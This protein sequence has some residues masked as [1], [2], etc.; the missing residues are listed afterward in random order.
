MALYLAFLDLMWQFKMESA[1]NLVYFQNKSS[2]SKQ[3]RILKLKVCVVSKSRYSNSLEDFFNIFHAR[4]LL[5]LCPNV[6]VAMEKMKN[7]KATVL[8]R[9]WWKDWNCHR[10]H[11][12]NLPPLKSRH[13]HLWNNLDSGQVSLCF[14]E[15][16]LP[17]RCSYKI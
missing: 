12:E 9:Q 14:N 1:V 5:R 8:K 15:K 6:F 10:W 3:P 17:L 16:N 11:Q 2:N 7:K 4:W 13:L